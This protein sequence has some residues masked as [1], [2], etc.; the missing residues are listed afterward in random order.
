M[1]NNYTSSPT[2]N[3]TLTEARFPL[4]FMAKPCT[5]TSQTSQ[6]AGKS[7]LNSPDAPRVPN[8]M[9]SPSRSSVRETTP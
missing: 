2:A 4:L 7:Q 9:T 3:P 8:G 5:T 1:S 6:P